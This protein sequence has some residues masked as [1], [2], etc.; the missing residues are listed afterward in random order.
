MRASAGTAKA[1]LKDQI[2]ITWRNPDPV[3]GDRYAHARA[4]V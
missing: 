2:A 3:V 1:I 4:I